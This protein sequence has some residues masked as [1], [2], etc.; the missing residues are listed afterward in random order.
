MD[1]Y[2]GFSDEAGRYQRVGI[3]RNRGDAEAFEEA[4]FTEIAKELFDNLVRFVEQID[5]AQ[6]TFFAGAVA[7]L[8]GL[9]QKL[10]APIDATKL[11]LNRN[12]LFA[13]QDT[14]K[15]RATNLAQQLAQKTLSLDDWYTGME[16]QVRR[17]IL[18]GRVSALGQG[19]LSERD[20]RAVQAQVESEL[21]YLQRFKAQLQTK[22]D[23]GEE[24]SA[25]A[26]AS[27]SR[28]YAGASTPEF[29]KAVQQAR[30]LPTL[31]AYPAVRTLCYSN[32]KCRWDIRFMEGEGNWDC[33]WE[34]N[35][36]DSCATCIAR[37]RTFAPLKIRNGI[38][39]PFVVKGAIYA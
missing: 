20:L 37:E 39:Q 6:L 5:V 3:A 27:R 38:I 18:A 7:L 15:D 8:A 31:P 30:G 21:R 22:L 35:A 26:I 9:R 25:D 32:C 12:A 4:G 19:N 24:L 13:F 17:N 34:R 1:R 14:V 11:P 10:N 29:E 16:A 36:N 28:M 2:Y 23:A 33:F